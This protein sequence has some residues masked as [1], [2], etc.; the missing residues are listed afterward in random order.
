MKDKIR[1]IVKRPSDKY[2]RVVHISNTLEKLQA[3][4]GGYIEIVPIAADVMIINE[5][6]KLL[7]L[8][9]NFQYGS[10]VICGTMVMVG[11]DGEEFGDCVLGFEAWKDWLDKYG[12]IGS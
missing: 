2:G 7:G 9:P 1:A 11:R 12:R 10:D 3:L 5:E 4:V 8:K 6:G